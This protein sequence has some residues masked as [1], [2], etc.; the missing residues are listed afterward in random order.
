VLNLTDQ[1]GAPKADP[2]SKLYSYW[3]AEIPYVDQGPARGWVL[4]Y[5]GVDQQLHVVVL[6]QDCWLW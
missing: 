3:G 2:N 4:I 5:V 1:T 6:Y